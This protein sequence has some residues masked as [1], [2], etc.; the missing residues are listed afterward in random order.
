MMDEAAFEAFQVH[1]VPIEVHLAAEGVHSVSNDTCYVT[2]EHT[3]AL[4]LIQSA[5][6]LAS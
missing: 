4:G 2:D 1:S 5:F 3:S 6:Q